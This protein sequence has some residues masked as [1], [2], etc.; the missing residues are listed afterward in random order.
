MVD[1]PPSSRN[2]VVVKDTTH[3]IAKLLLPFAEVE[4]A[5]II[6]ENSKSNNKPAFTSRITFKNRE[7]SVT[8]TR[9]PK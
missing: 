9:R 5:G 3:T 8:T 6:T 1:V 2:A 4:T 7:A